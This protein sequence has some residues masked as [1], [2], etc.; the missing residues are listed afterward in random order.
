MSKKILNDKGRKI[1]SIF[2]EDWYSKIEA[3]KEY[4]ISNKTIIYYFTQFQKLGWI[5]EKNIEK[6]FYKRKIIPIGKTKII[7][8]IPYPNKT[9]RY[10]TNYNFFFES[11]NTKLKEFL[12]FFLNQNF[13]RDYLVEV[14]KEDI[15]SGVNEVIKQLILTSIT[16]KKYGFDKDYNFNLKDYQEF[17]KNEIKKYYSNILSSKK[18]GKEYSELLREIYPKNSFWN[19]LKL[20]SLVLS[21]LFLKKGFRNELVHTLPNIYLWFDN[22]FD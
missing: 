1:F 13:T 9:L 10:R 3:S 2:F 5:E 11:Q 16:F 20:F 19:F 6:I 18:K 21:K 7:D 8:K 4:K 22:L 14:Y 15:P 17:I 12:L